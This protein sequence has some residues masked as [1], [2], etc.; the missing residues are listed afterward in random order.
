VA[1]GVPIPHSATLT[2]RFDAGAP[3]SG[4]GFSVVDLD[5]DSS[6]SDTGLLCPASVCT[7][8]AKKNDKAALQALARKLHQDAKKLSS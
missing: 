7:L 2:I 1:A 8:V 5:V 6:V 3:A 4:W